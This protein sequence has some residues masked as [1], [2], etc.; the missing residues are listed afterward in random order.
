M[1]KELEEKV[2]QKFNELFIHKR[3]VYIEQMKDGSYS[4]SSSFPYNTKLTDS[5]LI[6]HIKRKKTIGV[7]GNPNN[8][9]FLCFDIDEGEQSERIAKAIVSKIQEL[10][11]GCQFVHRVFSGSK[12]YHIYIFFNTMPYMSELKTFYSYVLQQCGFEDIKCDMRPTNTLGVKLPLSI[13]KKS[14]KICWFV[15]ENFKT[16]YDPQYKHFLSIQKLDTE[17]FRTI[18]SDIKKENKVK[19]EHKSKVM[20][21]YNTISNK[22]T[23]EDAMRIE[24]VGLTSCGTRNETCIIVAKL[25]NTQGYSKS[26]CLDKLNNWMDSQD[27][28]NY[29]TSRDA[30]LKENKKIVNWI[31][32]N[33][34]KFSNSKNTTMEISKDE[35]LNILKYKNASTKLLAFGMCIHANRFD[36]NCFYFARND[37]VDKCDINE[38]TIAKNLKILTDGNFITIINLREDGKRDISF[39]KFT[40]EFIRPKHQYKYNYSQI[41]SNVYKYDICETKYLQMISTILLDMFTKK[42]LTGLIGRRQYTTLTSYK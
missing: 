5:V 38:N 6:Q 23:R 1:E 24:Q 15:D 27:E 35:V 33:D 37:I 25:Y 13:N 16:I 4:Y 31:Y 12:G 41:D 34:V 26:D 10:G 30:W 17:Y 14:N 18:I 19:S 21:F 32:K 20:T 2:V 39:D 22:Y 11:V 36:K 40:G 28:C 7:F 42:E 3:S 8:A 9:K 29:T